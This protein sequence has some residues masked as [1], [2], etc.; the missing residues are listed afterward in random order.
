MSYRALTLTLLIAVFAAT[1]FPVRAQSK[2]PLASRPLA[3]GIRMDIVV[4][5]V[6]PEY[7]YEARRGHLTG[8]GILFGQVDAKTGYVTSVRMEKSTGYKI[9]D[10]AALNAFRQW[11]FKPGT[12]RKFRA[13]IVY[14]MLK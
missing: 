4:H 14:A 8:R 3:D 9:L 1:A 13:P 12:I 10:D 5:D 11:R 7:P 6:P 2:T